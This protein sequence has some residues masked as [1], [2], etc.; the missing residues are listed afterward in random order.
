MDCVGVSALAAI[1]SPCLIYLGSPLFASA[2]RGS[3]VFLSSELL[4][5]AFYGSRSPALYRPHGFAHSLPGGEPRFT[6]T[7]PA[8]PVLSI[9]P[10]KKQQRK[11]GM[12]SNHV[13]RSQ[14]PPCYRYTTLLLFVRCVTRDAPLVQPFTAVARLVSYSRP[15]LLFSGGG[16]KPQHLSCYSLQLSPGESL[17]TPAYGIEP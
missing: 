10:P 7:I 11:Q 16:G 14:I 6:A 5:S 12:E 13:L 4:R 1:Y 17:G 3:A 8:E 2:A 15:H 9:R